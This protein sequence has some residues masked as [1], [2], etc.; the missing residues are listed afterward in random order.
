MFSDELTRWER[1]TQPDAGSRV[2]VAVDIYDS[3]G[4]NLIKRNEY[5]T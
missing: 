2:L 1:R 3:N 5:A 4:V